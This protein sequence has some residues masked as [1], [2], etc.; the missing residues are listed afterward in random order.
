MTY[1]DELVHVCVCLCVCVCVVCVGGS[2]FCVWG[3]EGWV[4]IFTYFVYLKLFFL[5]V[6]YLALANLAQLE[7]SFHC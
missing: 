4:C 3:G 2:V 5:C 7:I 1:V 6:A